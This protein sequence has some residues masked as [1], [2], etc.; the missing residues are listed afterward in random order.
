MSIRGRNATLS[1]LGIMTDIIRLKDSMKHLR[2]ST[3]KLEWKYMIR[4]TQ[5]LY[6]QA[7][8]TISAKKYRT[9]QML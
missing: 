9:R 3:G 1:D 5:I 8:G 4:A 7:K 6:I 2:I